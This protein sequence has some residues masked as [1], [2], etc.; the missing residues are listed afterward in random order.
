[1]DDDGIDEGGNL[2]EKQHD[3]MFKVLANLGKIFDIFNFLF[4]KFNEKFK[5]QIEVSIK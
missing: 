5:I 1:M 2:N 4:H 3:Q